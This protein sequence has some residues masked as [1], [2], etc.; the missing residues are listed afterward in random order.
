MLSSVQSRRVFPSG[1]A[2]P[3]RQQLRM[4]GNLSGR[5]EILG[6]QVG[7]NVG[8][9]FGG[10]GEPLAGSAIGGELAGGLQVHAGQV[11]DRRIVLGITQTAQ[12]N[13]AGIACPRACFRLREAREPERA[14]CCFSAEVGWG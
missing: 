10:V 7:R 14:I 4:V 9:R 2:K 5:V 13:I 1:K 11:A 8:Q 6:E 3:V 12:G